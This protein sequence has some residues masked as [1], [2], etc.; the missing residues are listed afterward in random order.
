[1]VKTANGQ[2][3]FTAIEVSDAETKNAVGYIPVD[4][5]TPHDLLRIV[6][7]DGNLEVVNHLPYRITHSATFL[8]EVCKQLKST[9]RA[10][11]KLNSPGQIADGLYGI[12]KGSLSNIINIAKYVSA[13]EG[14][15]LQDAFETV[16][17]DFVNFEQKEYDQSKTKS[18]KIDPREY[19]Q[20]PNEKQK[21]GAITP[22][23]LEGC[24]IE[25]NQGL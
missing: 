12:F 21:S 20:K 23:A 22:K 3:Y 25:S 7:R 17:N 2:Y 9:D 18:G 14:K 8:R 1:M 15:S 6:F 19:E 24:I 11:L 5:V 13:K 16:L 4:N 10:K